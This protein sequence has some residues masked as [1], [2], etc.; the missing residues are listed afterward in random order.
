MRLK[1]LH[2]GIGIF[3][4]Y[5]KS[6]TAPLGGADHDIVYVVLCDDLNEIPPID[7]KRLGELGF[8]QSGEGWEFIT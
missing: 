4:K 5:L 3:L 1:D 2:E 6:H 7:L 8:R